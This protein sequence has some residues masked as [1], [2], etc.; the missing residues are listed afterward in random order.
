MAFESRPVVDSTQDACWVDKGRRA[1]V[2]FQ[3]KDECQGQ[4]CGHMS[5]AVFGRKPYFDEIEEAVKLCRD[6]GEKRI[7]WMVYPFEAVRQ[8]VDG[9]HVLF[10]DP[11]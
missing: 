11:A 6:H 5:V 7:K 10:K 4:E 1:S 9:Y 2:I 8:G 3:A